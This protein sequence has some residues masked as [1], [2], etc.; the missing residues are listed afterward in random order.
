MYAYPSYRANR[1]V[2]AA[3]IAAAVVIGALVAP[4]TLTSVTETTAPTVPVSVATAAQQVDPAAR[5]IA[6]QQHVTLGQAEIRLSWQQTVPSLDTALSSQLSAATFGGTWIAPNDG[7]RVKVGLVG[8][9]PRVRAVVMR[10]VSAVGL[11]GAVDLVPVQYSL[12]QL[13]SADAWL[14]AQFDKLPGAVHLDVSYLPDLNRV[15]LGVAG[16]YLSA[17]ER[18][19]ITRAKAR[20]GDLVQVVTQP[21]GSAATTSLSLDCV[22]YPVQYCFPSLRGGISITSTD[23]SGAISQCTG[24]FIAASRVDGKLYQFTAGHCV[25]P[26]GSGHTFTGTWSTKFPDLSTH[27]IGTVHNYVLGASGDEAI[28]NINNPSGWKLPQGWVYV[29]AGPNTTLNEE[30]P[31]S[32]ADY[33]TL[34]ARVCETG[35][36]SHTI[37]G[38]VLRLGVS[39]CEGPITKCTRVNNLGEA[40]FCG[41]EGDSGGPVYAS[42]QAFGLVVIGA[43]D[44]LLGYNCVTYYQGIIGAENTMNVNIVAAHLP[45]AMH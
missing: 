4:V 14:A 15:Q 34:G 27:A 5:T 33:S 22:P 13:V 29:M 43:A 6:A 1:P 8:A 38:T 41:G 35:A 23:S 30:Y 16:P 24:G 39:A 31:I 44:L 9:G 37:C 25:A 20:Y 36:T 18:V 10:A 40:S 3:I 19:L 45:V 11:S 7:D 12:G 17:A 26:P 42:H 21:A 2:K 28:L 32:S